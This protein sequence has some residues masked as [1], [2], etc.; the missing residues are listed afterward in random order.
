MGSLGH[1]ERKFDPIAFLRWGFLYELVM[2]PPCLDLHLKDAAVRGAT[3]S[4]KEENEFDS[5]EATDFHGNKRE[6]LKQGLEN[7]Q[8]TWKQITEALP[9][10]FLSDTEREVFLFTCKNMGIDVKGTP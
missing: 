7:G 5:P 9:R 3:M 1:E 4:E 2:N 8:L 6:L 10:Q